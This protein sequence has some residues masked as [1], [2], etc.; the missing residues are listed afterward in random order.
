MRTTTDRLRSDRIL[1]L[2]AQAQGLPVWI[3]GDIMIDEYVEGDVGRVSP[4]AP[5]PVVHVQRSFCRLGGSANVAHGAAALGAHAS[6][7]GAV[8]DDSTG[9]TVVSLCADLGID[10]R[11][12][13]RL[14]GR[15]TTR[16]LRVLARHQQ[17]LRLDW[18]TTE[19]PP[20]A[21]LSP[22]FERLQAASPPRAVD[23]KSV[24]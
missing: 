16:K 17:M 4:E 6:L 24:V 14:A 22:A 10:A 18:E 12:V 11:A 2:K 3:V 23:R 15:P 19:T 8:G 7:C 21:S 1:S 9:D 13:T 5:V 20:A